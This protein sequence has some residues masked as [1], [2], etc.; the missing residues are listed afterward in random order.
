MPEKKGLKEWKLAQK[1]HA[2]LALP[3]SIEDMRALFD[4]L[5]KWLGKHPC[6]HTLAVTKNHL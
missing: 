3:G 5:D 6:D 1:A 2:R 4:H